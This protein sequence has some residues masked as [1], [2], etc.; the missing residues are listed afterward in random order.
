MCQGGLGV[1][2]RREA[3]SGA[4][5]AVPKFSTNMPV[6]TCGNGLFHPCPYYACAGVGILLSDKDLTGLSTAMRLKP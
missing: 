1:F 4:S 3:D 2:C 6:N 5:P